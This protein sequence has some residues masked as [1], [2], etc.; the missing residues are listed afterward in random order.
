MRQPNK[1]GQ[2]QYS[3]TIVSSARSFVKHHRSG[4]TTGVFVFTGVVALAAGSAAVSDSHS[5][6]HASSLNSP[7]AAS[8]NVDAQPGT[9]APGAPPAGVDSQG[10]SVSTNVTT[11][12]TNGQVHTDVTVNGLPVEVPDNGTKSFTTPNGNVTVTTSTNQSSTGTAHNFN[13]SSNSTDI[14]SST[15]S[16]H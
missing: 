14:E 11:T 13:F 12:N 2:N 1:H 8:L 7:P 15:S 6:S 3:T 16:S 10:G 4:I 5:S 9:N